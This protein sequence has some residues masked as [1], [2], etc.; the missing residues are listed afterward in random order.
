M[1]RDLKRVQLVARHFRELQGLRLSLYGGVFTLV[2]GTYVLAPPAEG[3]GGIWIALAVAFLVIVPCQRLIERRYEST[4]GRVTPAPSNRSSWKSGAIGAGLF[5]TGMALKLPP[6]AA[7]LPFVACFSLWIV[8]RDWPWRV[9]HLAGFGAAL[10]ATLLLTTPAAASAP[11]AST[12]SALLL[13]GLAYVPV[14]L[15]DHRLLV[16]LMRGAGPNAAAGSETEVE[17]RSRRN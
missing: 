12:A 17:A 8:I 7:A 14:G 3:S 1:D 2:F 16:S 9:H 13:F 15:L 4:F 10:G 6:L 11:D 5:L